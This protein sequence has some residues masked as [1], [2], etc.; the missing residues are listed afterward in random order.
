MSNFPNEFLATVFENRKDL[1]DA[2]LATHN[3]SQLKD[4][5]NRFSNRTEVLKNQKFQS[6]LDTIVA[7]IAFK[8]QCGMGIGKWMDLHCRHWDRRKRSRIIELCKFSAGIYR[9]WEL[10]KHNLTNSAMT[11]V[12]AK[13]FSMRELYDARNLSWC[14]REVKR[15]S[16]KSKSKEDNPSQAYDEGKY[17]NI[18]KKIED[19]QILDSVSFDEDQADLIAD[20]I[21]EDLHNLCKK[22]RYGM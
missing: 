16:R 10:I 11:E 12:D 6:N 3:A 21:K 4:I 14:L 7:C 15:N 13:N 19:E 8:R 5:V 18:L 2:T 22:A 20:R 9:N 1:L 17:M